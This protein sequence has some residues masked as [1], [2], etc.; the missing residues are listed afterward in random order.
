[1]NID[2]RKSLY[3]DI[4]IKFAT[5]D[6]VDTFL[7]AQDGWGAKVANSVPNIRVAR[8]EYAWETAD[9]LVRWGCALDFVAALAGYKPPSGEVEVNR[10]GDVLIIDVVDHGASVTLTLR[11]D[12][13]RLVAAR[14]L[15]LVG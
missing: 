13:A 2:R 9:R 12:V 6:D 10:S 7:R 3:T 4:L 8:E 5:N 11:P 14:I 15:A 1:M